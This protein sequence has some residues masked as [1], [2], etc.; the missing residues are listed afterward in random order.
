MGL[1]LRSVLGWLMG[2]VCIVCCFY[3]GNALVTLAFFVARA[4][5]SLLRA[6]ILAPRTQVVISFRA[7]LRQFTGVV[8]WR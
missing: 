5:E 2:F 8:G 6:D 3:C 1:S 4:C 7:V